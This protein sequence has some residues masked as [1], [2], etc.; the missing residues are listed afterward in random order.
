MPEIS[1][2]LPENV[3]PEEERPQLEQ[4]DPYRKWKNAAVGGLLGLIVSGGIIAT[5]GAGCSVAAGS[6]TTTIELL[7]LT[8]AQTFAIGA[9]V[10]DLG[11]I[12]ISAFFGV[13]ME[14]IEYEP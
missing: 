11:A 12:I 13:E 8:G 10:Y 2:T 3:P 6:A 1:C 5:G 4:D 14:T 9:L 7:G